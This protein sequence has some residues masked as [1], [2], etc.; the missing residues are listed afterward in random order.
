MLT[1]SVGSKPADVCSGYHHQGPGSNFLPAWDRKSRPG[2]AHCCHVPHSH[3][4]HHPLCGHR[5]PSCHIG[6]EERGGKRRHQLLQANQHRWV[7]CPG[8]KPGSVWRH[9]TMGLEHLSSL[10]VTPADKISRSLPSDETELGAAS[11]QATTG[12]D[13]WCNIPGPEAGWNTTG[14]ELLCL[15]R[16]CSKPV[17]RQSRRADIVA[18]A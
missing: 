10:A 1:A 8:T 11:P 2:E 16:P 12:P 7:R 13:Q 17:Q 5:H 6:M 14:R 3:A 9:C 18:S 15:T 4:I